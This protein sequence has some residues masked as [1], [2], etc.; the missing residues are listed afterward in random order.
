MAVDYLKLGLYRAN[1][2]QQDGIIFHTGMV[3]GDS[4]EDVVP[5]ATTASATDP[6][7]PP[8]TTGTG[9]DTGTPTSAAP[10]TQG[11][12]GSNGGAQAGGCSMAGTPGSLLSFA[13]LIGVALLRTRRRF[14][15]RKS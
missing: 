13:G 15:R 6:N 11:P 5:P 4:F 2:I 7:T 10:L 3:E 14:S 1:T 9:T 12:N 8:A